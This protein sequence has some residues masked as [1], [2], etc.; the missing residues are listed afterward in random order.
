MH[1]LSP[2][3]SHL[4]A[5]TAH[6]LAFLR[7]GLETYL[8]LA[9]NGTRSKPIHRYWLRAAAATQA[10]GAQLV[11]SRTREWQA[12]AAEARAVQAWEQAAELEKAVLELE[13]L[14]GAWPAVPDGSLTR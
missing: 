7:R 11:A 14:L 9:D 2:A 4:P 10:R 12:S 3:P 5:H 1:A 6:T 13:M 8:S